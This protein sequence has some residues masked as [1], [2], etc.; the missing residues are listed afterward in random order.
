MDALGNDDLQGGDAQSLG[1]GLS[2]L[3][4]KQLGRYLIGQQLGSGGVATVYRA[5]DQVQGQTVALK[6]L[7]PGADDKAYTR[8]RNEAMTAGALRHPHI[9]R[10]LQI[11][12]APQG[13]VA[14]IAMELVEGESLADLLRQHGRLRPQESANL[15]EPIARALALAHSQGVVHRDVKPGNI[16]LRPTSPGAPNSIQLEALDYPVVPLL[17]DFGIARAL[18]APELTNMGRTV[19]T[20][21]Y[22]APEQ[23]AG[24]R[25]VDGRADVYALGA[26]LYRCIAGRLPFTGT[27][28]QILHAHVYEPLTIDESVYRQLSPLMVEVLQRSLAKRPED[29]YATTAELG[30]A[31]VLAAGRTPLRPDAATGEATATLTMTALS[32]LNSPTETSS[33]TVLVP[34]PGGSLPSRPPNPLVRPSPSSAVSSKLLTPPTRT[35]LAPAVR[36]DPAPPSASSS[37]DARPAF[38]SFSLILLGG[39]LVMALGV[40]L[41]M[42]APRMLQGR[43]TP[44]LTATVDA[45]TPAPAVVIAPETPSP[46]PTA[47]DDRGSPTPEAVAAPA[48]ETPSPPPPTDTETPAPTATDTPAP[49]ETPSPT[50]T[51]TA[52]PDLDATLTACLPSVDETLRA[53]VSGLPE[54][55]WREIGCP[56][57]QAQVGAAQILPL[58]QGYM[59]GFENAPE[60][61]VVYFSTN[62]WERQP[63]P[64]ASEPPPDLPAAPENRYLPEGRFAALWQADRR[65]E[66]LGFAVEP[67][68]RTSVVAIQG[69]EGAVLVGNRDTG[70]ASILFNTNRR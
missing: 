19:G 46:T 27:T 14:Y 54:E 69:F 6:L 38:W 17:T 31:L 36:P 5:Y 22:M 21:A 66:A 59:V 24:S 2:N 49:T 68:P 51:A 50:E 25:E 39:F 47:Q 7:L 35:A 56:I 33:T 20:P 15:L 40:L 53:H 70:E 23:C 41:G 63:I 57:G 48:T 65:W 12:T 44:T 32:V 45:T 64:D 3:T 1:A 62:E 52:T 30:D 58:E 18:D 4:G 61:F 11:G 29:R 28:T 67:Q 10:I 8:F 26:V 42:Q 9:V 16:L 13:E 55:E 43:A 60:L 37:R 34:A